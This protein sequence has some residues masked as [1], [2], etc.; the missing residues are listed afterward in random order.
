M[1]LTLLGEPTCIVS[2]SLTLRV[3]SILTLIGEPTCV[4]SHSPTFCIFSILT[5]LSEPTCIVSHSPTF[6]R[7][8][9]VCNEA[10]RGGLSGRFVIRQIDVDDTA[11]HRSVAIATVVVYT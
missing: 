6:R 9:S 10:A 5:L 11:S 4:V 1:M 3:L 8:L 7:S 2:H